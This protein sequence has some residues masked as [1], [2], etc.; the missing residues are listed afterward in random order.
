MIRFD[1]YSPQAQAV[2]TR[3]YTIVQRYAHT[4][5]DTE[6]FLLALLEQPDTAVSQILAYLKVDVPALRSAVVVEL[7][8][9][10]R[11]VKY[12]AAGQIFVAVRLRQLLDFA[13]KEADNLYD[14]R[15]S[16]EHLLLAMCSEQNSPT[17]RLLN[18]QGV[19]RDRVK[20]ALKKF[21]AKG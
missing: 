21:R 18:D 12:G 9:A 11:T 17:A 16:T 20:D 14:E 6:H 19:S 5:M 7:E 3:A 10:P 15:L 8:S 4:L 2:A 13:L 1:G